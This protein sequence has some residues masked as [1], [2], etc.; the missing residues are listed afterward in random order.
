M[1]LLRR[2][3]TWAVPRTAAG[4]AYAAAPR[5]SPRTPWR[6]ARWCVVDLEL[7]GLDPER[8]EI[9]AY[10]AVPVESGR[11][12]LPGSV[13]ALVRPARPLSESSIRI[14]GLL[15]ADLAQAPPLERA[16]E[17]LLAAMTGRIL[18]AH[19]AGVERG[20]LGPA[21]RRQGLRLRRRI[22]DTAVLGRLWL[23]ERDGRAPG[24]LPLSSLAAT[25]GLPAERPHAALSD[26][27]TT[28]QVFVALATHLDARRPETV[29][30]LTDAQ[31]RLDS[32]LRY[33]G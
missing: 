5:P 4:A 20:F 14:H 31:A 23:Y 19:A 11:V 16:L 2:L 12:L 18:V 26:A 7:S 13:S 29:R 33:L 15:A 9:I 32:S 21:L 30:S 8:H 17:P 3:G 22:V 28:A 1:T 6:E 24:H 10:G 25:L 27:L